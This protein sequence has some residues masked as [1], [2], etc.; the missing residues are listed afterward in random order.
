M[1]QK[2]CVKIYVFQ[3]KMRL[4]V[5]I[6]G[7]TSMKNIQYK[8]YPVFFILSSADCLHQNHLGA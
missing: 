6:N 4:L 2:E 7:Y 1:C 3:F 5:V 8:I